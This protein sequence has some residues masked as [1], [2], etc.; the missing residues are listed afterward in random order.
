MFGGQFRVCK[1][2]WEDNLRKGV[3]N[4]HPFGGFHQI[5]QYGSKKDFHTHRPNQDLCHG[6][7]FRLLKY[8]RTVPLRLLAEKCEGLECK[9][10]ARIKL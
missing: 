5:S 9:I 10:P 2:C 7:S 3:R 8:G 6:T 4:A 1:K